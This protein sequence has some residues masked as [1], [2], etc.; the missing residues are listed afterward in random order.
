VRINN[1]TLK[2]KKGIEQVFDLLRM[3]SHVIESAEERVAKILWSFKESIVCDCKRFPQFRG[4]QVLKK[5]EIAGRRESEE[6]VQ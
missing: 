5:A 3:V 1:S 6:T 2:S 4:G